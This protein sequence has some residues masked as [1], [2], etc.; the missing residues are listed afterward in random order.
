M[1]EILGARYF[2]DILIWDNRKDKSGLNGPRSRVVS[3]K[4]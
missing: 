3:R 2:I 4:N 1:E